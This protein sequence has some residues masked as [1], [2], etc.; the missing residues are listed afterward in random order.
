MRGNILVVHEDL[1]V[2]VS[3]F[4]FRLSR[5]AFRRFTWV[6][7]QG[8][9]EEPNRQ[10]DREKV[11]LESLARLRTGPVHEETEPQVRQSAIAL[12]GGSEIRPT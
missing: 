12:K 1:H 4:E 7:V 5:F 9:G 2:P 6:D 3:S 10:P 8:C 11:I